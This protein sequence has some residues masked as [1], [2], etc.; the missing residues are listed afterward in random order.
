[1]LSLVGCDASYPFRLER[2]SDITSLDG[3]TLQDESVDVLNT[4]NK[5]V[6]AIRNHDGNGVIEY[7]N[8]TEYL[9]YFFAN[10]YQGMD[11]EEI[12]K[13]LPEGE[14]TSS[15]GD[16]SDVY[17]TTAEKLTDE[18]FEARISVIKKSGVD[19]SNVNSM[20]ILNKDSSNKK[21]MYA[22]IEDGKCYLDFY[23]TALYDFMYALESGV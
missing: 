10:T 2:D 8:Y 22:V 11:D 19:V 17:F 16:T 5:A 9:K 1:M 12:M 3:K 6:E 15:A 13:V 7:T 20:Y 14:I 23:Y 18:D 4:V 21:V